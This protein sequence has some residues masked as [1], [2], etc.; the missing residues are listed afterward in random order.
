MGLMELTEHRCSEA[1]GN[2]ETAAKHYEIVVDIE[3]LLDAP[4][5][6]QWVLSDMLCGLESRSRSM[7]SLRDWYS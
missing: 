4:K 1:M 7:V 3:A 2:I 5:F 6:L